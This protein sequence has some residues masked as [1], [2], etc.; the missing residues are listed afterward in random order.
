[1]NK[2]FGIVI[3]FAAAWLMY[4]L[5]AGSGACRGGS[6]GGEN[7]DQD[8][9]HNCREDM[10]AGSGTKPGSGCKPDTGP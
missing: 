3:L 8:H 1:M 9:S 2:I 4:R 7:P 10:N 5:Q 6:H